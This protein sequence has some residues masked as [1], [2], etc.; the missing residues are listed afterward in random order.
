MKPILEQ[1]KKPVK[2]V[3]P[4]RE[5]IAPMPQPA[6]TRPL[7]G[8]TGQKR[9]ATAPAH[10][11]STKKPKLAAPYKDISIAEAARYGTLQEYAF[12]DKVIFKL[13]FI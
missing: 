12:F 8:Q 7:H 3:P 6:P 2:S 11:I 9:N 5:Y 4:P 1:P 10:P 13:K